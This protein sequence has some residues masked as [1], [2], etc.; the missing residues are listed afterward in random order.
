[1]DAILFKKCANSA[2]HLGE[3]S[4]VKGYLFLEFSASGLFWSLSNPGE[5][6]DT[7]M[8]IQMDPRSSKMTPER[9]NFSMLSTCFMQFWNS[10]CFLVNFLN[11]SVY[12]V[13]F[14]DL[15]CETLEPPSL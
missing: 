5:P 8:D 10:V 7:E 12:D 14:H 15:L 3:Y 1:M 4:A 9:S 2:S 11:V 13:F 6:K